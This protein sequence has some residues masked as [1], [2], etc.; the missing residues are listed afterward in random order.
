M[1]PTGELLLLARTPAQHL[2]RCERRGGS[3]RS[4]AP[5]TISVTSGG[6]VERMKDN[7]AKGM[8]GIWSLTPSQVEAV[9]SSTALTPYRDGW[10]VIFVEPSDAVMF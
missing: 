9:M 10:D 3:S 4:T 8:T 7:R 2:T 1:T 5:T 6:Y